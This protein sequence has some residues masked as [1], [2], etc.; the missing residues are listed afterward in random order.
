M[1]NRYS[2]ADHV[3][4]ISFPNQV[5][6]T[7]T[8]A[9]TGNT[10]I[11]LGGPGESGE[12]SFVGK[13]TVERA[14]ETW[15][16][17]ADPTGSWVNN[18]TLDKHGTVTI[19]IR[20]ISDAVI[21]LMM[22]TSAYETVDDQNSNARGLT[23]NVYSS[24]SIVATC[25]DCYIVKVPSQEYNATANEQTWTFTCGRILFPQTTAWPT[26]STGTKA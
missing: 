23:I 7:A 24:N 12:G 13:I 9:S 10:V 17:D 2:L 11:S 26:E 4:K 6:P 15:T 19:D 25:E 14:T 18:K 5:L 3:V 8:A 21:Q 20:Q 16:T 1:I 22:L